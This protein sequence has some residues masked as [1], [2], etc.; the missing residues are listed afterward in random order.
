MQ[1]YTNS[2]HS[3][4]SICC[5]F[6][7]IW[8]FSSIGF[9]SLVKYWS[10]I[11]WQLDTSPSCRSHTQRHTKLQ[12]FFMWILFH[13]IFAILLHFLIYYNTPPTYTVRHS[14]L[15]KS[16]QKSRVRVE[17][18][19]MQKSLNRTSWNNSFY[20]ISIH[21]VPDDKCKYQGLKLSGLWHLFL[22]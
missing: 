6:S 2:M 22:L 20:D 5:I 10:L 19:G 17:N 3:Y 14:S 16:A 12:L 21:T 7:K 9:V 18:Q 13:F 1:N 8:P 4:Q 15:I 11:V